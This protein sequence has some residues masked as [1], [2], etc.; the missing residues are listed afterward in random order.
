MSTPE[1]GGTDLATARL[2][3]VRQLAHLLD[4]S[5]RIPGTRWRVG[6]DAIIGLV[7]GIGDAA[8]GALSLYIV[9]KAARLGAGRA[10][11]ARMLANVGIEVLVGA[12]PLLGDLFDAAWKANRRNVRLLESHLSDPGAVARRSRLWWAAI[13]IASISM[14]VALGAAALWLTAALLRAIG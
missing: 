4:T 3:G 1:N 7:P 12:V 2:Q 8:G 5:I 14:V 6:L 10:T 11:L 9:L 13:A